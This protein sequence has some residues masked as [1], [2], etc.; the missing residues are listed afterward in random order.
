MRKSATIYLHSVNRVSC[1]AT[2]SGSMNNVATGATGGATYETM[3]CAINKTRFVVWLG[4][5]M[6]KIQIKNF[7]NG[8]TSKAFSK[9]EAVNRMHTL[10]VQ[11]KMNQAI[12]KCQTT[13]LTRRNTVSRV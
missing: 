5:S 10:F 4:S 1:A 11:K 9:T 13:A 6:D 12:Y 7:L 8:A 3:R 2:Q